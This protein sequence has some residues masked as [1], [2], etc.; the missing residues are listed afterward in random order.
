MQSPEDFRGDRLRRSLIDIDQQVRGGLVEGLPF[1]DEGFDPLADI[2]HLQERA[3]VVAFGA[4][5]EKIDGALEV[6]DRPPVPQSRPVV[7]AQHRAAA[8][9]EDDA[10]ARAQLVDDLLLAVAE[11]LFALQFE[12]PRDVRPGA[13]LDD[14]VGVEELQPETRC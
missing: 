7:F 3:T 8:G 5:D 1:G 12:D 10:V 4:V 9:R 11:A 13:F 14:L 6:Q 2:V